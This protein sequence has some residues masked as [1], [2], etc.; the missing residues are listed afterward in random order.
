[1]MDYFKIGIEKDNK[2]MPYA[3]DNIGEDDKTALKEKYQ[4]LLDD[5]NKLMNQFP[6]VKSKNSLLKKFDKQLY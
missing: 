2:K 4:Q 1:M 3:I 5:K 6:L